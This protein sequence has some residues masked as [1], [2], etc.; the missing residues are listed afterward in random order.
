MCHLQ[1]ALHIVIKHSGTTV[2]VYDCA[3]GDSKGQ[4][5]FASV[6]QSVYPSV[7]TLIVAFLD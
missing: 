6:C 4:I 3:A 7:G 1:W 2:P 5:W